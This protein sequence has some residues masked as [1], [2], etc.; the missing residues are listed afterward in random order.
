[1]PAHRKVFV[2]GLGA[3]KAGT[4]WLHDYLDSDPGADFGG[5]KEYHVWDALTLQ[6][7]AHFDMRPGRMV[8]RALMQLVDRL[9]SRGPEAWSLRG[10]LQ[11]NPEKYFDYFDNLLAQPGIHLTGDITP[12]YAAL[13]TGTLAQVKEGFARR[14]IAVKA[15]FIMRDPV[16]RAVSAAQMNRRKRD[17][18]EGVPLTGGIDSAVLRYARSRQHDLR[19][20]YART[21]ARMREVFAPGE[22]H[23]GIYEAMFAPEAVEAL[24]QTFGV[25]HRPDRIATRV[26]DAGSGGGPRVSEETKAILRGLLDETYRFCAGEFPETR[27]LWRAAA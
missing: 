17:W 27:T 6:E 20:N 16:A 7:A 15:V 24:S 4:S 13:D 8:N 12:S 2:L 11:Q 1:M 10:E 3:Q 21:V 9:K 18:R 22:L 25:A 23:L 5:L 19:A 26:Y 14:D